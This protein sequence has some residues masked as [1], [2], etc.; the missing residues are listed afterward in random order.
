M[1]RIRCGAIGL[2]LVLS[3]CGGEAGPKLP[4]ATFLSPENVNHQ[5]SRFSP[6][7]SRVAYW[8]PGSDGWDLIVAHGDLSSPRTVSSQNIQQWGIVWSP[9]SKQLAFGAS[10]GSS[11]DIMVVSADSGEA[12]HLTQAGGTEVPVAWHP[13]GNIMSYIATGQG[14]TIRG[15]FLDLASGQTN[16][17]PGNPLNNIAAWSPDGS[18]LALA[19]FQGNASM[20]VADSVGGNQRQLTP[21]GLESAFQWSPDGKEIAYVSRRTG[22]GDIWVTPVAGGAPRQLTRDIRNDLS[23]VWSPDGK[24]IAFVS[25]RGRQTDLWVVPAAGG[26]EIRVTDDAAEEG[27]IQWVGKSEVL[28]YHTGIA[29]QAIW[30][31]S[32]EDGKERRLTAD[33]L[34]VVNPFPSP[35]GKEVVYQVL[36]GGGVSDLQVM[37]MA[38]GAARTLVEGTWNNFGPNWSPDGK[39]IVFLSNRS[40]NVDLWVVSAAGGEPRQ[41]TDF[42]TDENNP[43]WSRDGAFVYFMSSHDA[44]PFSDVWKVPVAGGAPVRMTKTGTVNALAVSLVSADVFVQS[45]SGNAGQ[46]ILG[47]VLP[48]GKIQ[49]LWDKGNVTGISWLGLTPKGDSIAI[50]AQLPGGGVGSYLLSTRTGQGRQVLGKGDQIG[51]FSFDG[52]WLA[53]WMGTAT[54]DIGLIDMKD[55]STRQL[56]TSPESEVSYWWT[57]DNKTIVL[58]RQSQRRRIATVDLTKLLAAGK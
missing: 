33:S 44:A 17:I 18:Q 31:I 37:P 16:A 19:P 34:R 24:W 39:F 32:V 58:A 55:G 28:A 26:A 57:A 41:L 27:N 25:Q 30:T 23:P 50:N 36:R 5:G 48:E 11:T 15:F 45:V 12:R 52:R 4:V 14:G 38:G 46:T 8:A 56:T 10:S 51:D 9:D 29:G 13:R 42:S 3:A 49:T 54:L 43:E 1:T 7:G 53:Y 40:G 22:T 20:W 47:K 6:D 21:E 35:D 2:L